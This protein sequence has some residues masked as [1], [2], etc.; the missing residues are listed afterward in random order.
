MSLYQNKTTEYSSRDKKWFRWL[1]LL[2]KIFCFLIIFF[3]INFIIFSNNILISSDS[4]FYKMPVVSSIKYLAESNYKELA[5]EADDRI[6]ILVLGMGGKNHE[7]GYLADT[8][9]LISLKPSINK[10]S[11]ISVPR[12]LIVPIDGMGWKKI[13]SINA[14]AEMNKEN[15]GGLATSQALSNLLNIPINYFVRVDFD[16]FVNIIDKFG[17]IEIYAENALKDCADPIWGEEMLQESYAL[18]SKCL[19]IAKGWQTMDGLLALKYAR[20]RHAL[21]PE[22]SDFARARH[23]QKIIEAIKNKILSE[24]ILFKPK[25]ILEIINELQNNISTNLKIW[26]MIKLWNTYKNIPQN[27]IINKVIDNRSDGLLVDSKGEDGAYI[28]IPRTGD[29]TQLQ[30]L[31]QNI[32]SDIQVQNKIEIISEKASVEIRNGT[33]TNGFA[34]AMSTN[35]EQHGFDITNISN[36]SKQN[37]QKSII[38]DLTYGEKKKSLDVLKKIT[39]ANVSLGLPQWLI[40]EIKLDLVEQKNPVQPD[41]ILIL[42]NYENKNSSNKN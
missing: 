18:R 1:K 14:Y 13:N 19:N 7:G 20:S 22:G 10:V 28:L 21:G 17:G 39:N 27:N 25:L 37:L 2:F 30:N 36:Q 29:F 24:H 31:V 12:D 42:Y 16:G 33:L 34:K 23:Q 41:F 8:I 11:M 38:Y 26:E 6:N 4:W 32:F 5:G 35:L 3:I 15:S 9:M 40:N